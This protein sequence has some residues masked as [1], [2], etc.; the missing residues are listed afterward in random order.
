MSAIRVVCAALLAL[1][2]NRLVLFFMLIGAAFLFSGIVA[3][4][5]PSPG[6]IPNGNLYYCGTCHESGHNF[7]DGS[8]PVPPS[9]VHGNAMQFPFL[10]TT[11]TKTWTT[12]LANQDSDGDGFTNGEEL[13]DPAGTWAIGQADPGDI[14]F[15]SNPSD[16]NPANDTYECSLA[17]RAT[18]P[19]PLLLDV[20]GYVT[21]AQS[22]VSFGA[23][24]RSPLPIDYIRYTV[25]N[26]ASQTVYDNFSANAPFHSSVW[27]TTAVPDG[28]YTITALV[29]ERRAQ[30]GVTARTSS[31][32]ESFTIKNSAPVFGPVGEV[33]GTPAQPCGIPERLNGI[34]TISADNAWAA[35]TRFIDGPGD[36]MLIKHWDGVRWTSV[37]SPNASIYFNALHAVAATG[38]NDVW[39]AGEYDYGSLTQTLIEHWDGARWQIIASPNLGASNN[40]LA[41]IAAISAN[42][43]WAVGSYDDGNGGSLPL[44]LRWNGSS[45]QSVQAPAPSGASEVTLKSIAAVSARD[46]WAV[47]SYTDF[48]GNTLRKTLT[49]H[50]NGSQWKIVASPNPQSFLNALNSVTTLAAND[51]WAVGYTS[52][53][54]YKTMALHWNGM[55]WQAATTPSPGNPNN[56]LLAIAAVAANDIWAVG[57]AGVSADDG[58][59][60]TLHWD[61]AAWKG[62]ARPDAG[63]GTLNA[64]DTGPSGE[65]WAAGT[66]TSNSSL[67]RTL[68]ERYVV[69]QPPPLP[70]VTIS[71]SDPSAAEA[72]LDA[73]TMTVTRSGSIAA[74]LLVHYTVGGSATPGADYSALSGSVTIA[75]GKSSATIAVTPVNDPNIEGNE[76]VAV[77]LSADSAYRLG[78]D[79]SASVTIA[80]DDTPT[81][82]VTINASDSNAAEAGPQTGGLTVTRSGSTA[83]PLLVHYTVGGT[84]TAGSDYTALAGTISIPAGQA[85]ATIAVVPIDDAAVEANETVLVTLSADPAYTVGANAGATVTIIDN[86]GAG[87]PGPQLYLPLIKR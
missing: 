72:G 48:S 9:P 63:A 44:L 37:I 6:K 39:A 79:V 81:Q 28:N 82:I 42:N 11:P 86:D 27:N 58:Q 26:G 50:W 60:L 53:G 20:I 10:N 61:G 85:S 1:I 33:V 3:A 41:G 38:A 51:V 83:A 21:P 49:L 71:A 65:A 31:R 59:T 43:A 25:K 17:Y 2:R 13:Q 64:L 30:G 40:R 4:R 74:P 22:L 62:V 46:I 80:D 14:G 47:G 77:T 8:P 36:Q 24:V 68:V 29:V 32:S 75:T 12:D 34:A 78:V 69:T 35:G 7:S 76:T 70:T 18:P 57:Y 23:S 73:G 55:N 52:N 15:V 66:D 19:A 45:W 84:A 56:E 54:G 87:A 16:N 5:P 67:A